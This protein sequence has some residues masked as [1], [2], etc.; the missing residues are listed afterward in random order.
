MTIRILIIDDQAENVETLKDELER[1]LDCVC[2]IIGFAD[3]RTT[4]LSY[5]P[6]VVVLDVMEGLGAEPRMTGLT[7]S[8]FIWDEKFCPL[9]FYTAAADQVG[10][11]YHR[12]HPFVC[13]ISKGINSEQQVLIRI[14]EFAPQITAL[15]EVSDEIR[16]TMNGALRAIAPGLFENLDATTRQSLLLRSARRRV[17]AMMDDSI[18]TGNPDLMPWEL[19]LCPPVVDK[20]LLTGDIIRKRNGEKTNPEN[21]SVV[22]TPS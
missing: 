5:N 14:Q 2:K 17:A 3:A 8:K 6:H 21:Y 15:E 18:S 19:Y 13:I 1:Q 11:E 4:I 10:E 9:V 12:N 22:L 7:T 20:H 16:W